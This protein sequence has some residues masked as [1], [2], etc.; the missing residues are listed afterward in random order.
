MVRCHVRQKKQGGFVALVLVLSFS[1]LP[2]FLGSFR[3]RSSATHLAASDGQIVLETEPA[4]DTAEVGASRSQ[5]KWKLLR[6]SAA[7]DRGQA[8]NPTSGEYY[9]D[10]LE[11]ARGILEELVQKSPSLPA[12][13]SEIDGEWELIFSTVKHG[14]FRS[15]PF[16][17]AVQEAFGAREK[18]DLFFKLHELQVMS[19]GA[20]KVGRVAQYINSTEGRL[21]SEFDTSLL[22]M[23][24]IPILGFWKLLP[25]IGGCVVTASDVELL[26]DRL[27]MEVQYTEAK[28]VPGLP[29]LGEFVMNRKVP[30]NDIWQ[31]LPWNN[32]GKPTC[33]VTLKYVDEDMRIVA[34]DDGEMFVYV[35]PVDPRGL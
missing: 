25:T 9:A 31:L 7:L 5:L 34:D 11:V 33:G 6:M 23:T 28:E 16:F 4:V 22:S 19:W 18:S 26:G 30:V 24:V 8:Y 27:A 35:R 29:P 21:Y 20:S 2:C 14:I 12:N 15:S 3:F 10:R 1:G 17:L 32:G 13:L